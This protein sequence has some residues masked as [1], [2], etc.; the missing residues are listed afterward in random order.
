MEIH[1]IQKA[2][3]AATVAGEVTA[4][5][6]EEP[7]TRL[8]QVAMG[9]KVVWAT[10]MVVMVGMQATVETLLQPDNRVLKVGRVAVVLM[11]DQPEAMGAMGA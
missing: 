7:A 9:V 2:V 5:L 4:T 3:K 1:S 11:V 8:D 10:T 6:L